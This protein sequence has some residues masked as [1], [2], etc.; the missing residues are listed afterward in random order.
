MNTIKKIIVLVSLYIFSGLSSAHISM[1]DEIFHNHSFINFYE[2]FFYILFFLSLFLG[3]YFH[4]KRK[5][6]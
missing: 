4:N 1:K 2:I 5:N 3:V 6:N